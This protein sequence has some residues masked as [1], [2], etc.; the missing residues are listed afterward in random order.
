MTDR[1]VTEREA[2]EYLGFKPATLRQS[3]WTGQLAG[4]SA[5]TH[6]TFGRSIRY[7]SQELI[8]WA[9]RQAEE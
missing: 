1:F 2:A 3:R 8:N 7:K 5:P 6:V 4:T 9:N